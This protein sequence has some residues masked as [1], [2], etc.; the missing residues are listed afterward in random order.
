M[1]ISS[2]KLEAIVALTREHAIESL[3]G[4]KQGK[5]KLAA[6]L[7][8]SS[9]WPI[10]TAVNQYKTHP[11]LVPFFKY[12]YLHAEANTILKKGLDNCSGYDIVVVR[13]RRDNGNV[14]M[15]KP[16]KCCESLINHVGIKN[17]YYTNWNGDI[18]YVPSCTH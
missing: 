10:S 2:K 9:G 6:T 16:C 8:D 4:T 7:V 1:T 5:F 13:V 12:P 15:A 18:E 3:G 14:T 17:I 11:A